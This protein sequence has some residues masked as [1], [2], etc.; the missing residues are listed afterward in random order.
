MHMAYYVLSQISA[1]YL[2]SKNVNDGVMQRIG[3]LRFVHIKSSC[4][5]LTSLFIDP[6]YFCAKQLKDISPRELLVAVNYISQK[7]QFH[8]SIFACTF[9]GYS[10]F[11]KHMR[12]MGTQQGYWNKLRTVFFATQ[13]TIAMFRDIRERCS[14]QQSFLGIWLVCLGA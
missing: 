2:S 10:Y 3:T 5:S 7:S 1:L 8:S 13:L 9:I 14:F 11:C 6:I 4:S 12:D